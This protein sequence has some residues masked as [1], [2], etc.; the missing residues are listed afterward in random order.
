M[1]ASA[2]AYI[3]PDTGYG[4]TPAQIAAEILSTGITQ[5]EA[6]AKMLAHTGAI[7]SYNEGAAQRYADMGVAVMAW[8][9]ADDD[10]KCPFCA[11]MNGKRVGT[12]EPF[13]RSGDRFS[14][15]PED[16]GAALKMSIPDGARAFD[17]EHH[18]LHPNCR[19]TIIPVIEENA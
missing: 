14:I 15:D 13:F 10:M 1:F 12:G 5:N 9:T 16:G 11:E 17:V 7:W 4:M 19:C 8:L 3:D 6:R 2:A 18:P